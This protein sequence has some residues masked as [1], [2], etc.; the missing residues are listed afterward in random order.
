MILKGLPGIEGLMAA[1]EVVP[2]KRWDDQGRRKTE[3][4][5][6]VSQN[7]EAERNWPDLLCKRSCVRCRAGSWSWC[8]AGWVEHRGAG[9]ALLQPIYSV[10]E[11]GGRAAAGN[12]SLLGELSHFSLSLLKSGHFITLETRKFTACLICCSLEIVRMWRNDN[13]ILFLNR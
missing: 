2:R 12:L 8:R 6:L 3:G 9:A 1:C 4:S 11:R 7:E 13:K 5:L 10:T